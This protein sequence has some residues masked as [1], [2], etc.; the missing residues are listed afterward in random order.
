MKSYQYRLVILAFCIMAQIPGV[1][2]G[3]VQE[4]EFDEEYVRSIINNNV[5]SSKDGYSTDV[6]DLICRIIGAPDI[7]LSYPGAVS[8]QVG[9]EKEVHI[10]RTIWFLRH[11]MLVASGQDAESCNA[12]IYVKPFLG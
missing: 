3:E 7:L 9:P 11:H 1:L 5:P 2:G 4:I 12:W 6:T 8:V 10:S